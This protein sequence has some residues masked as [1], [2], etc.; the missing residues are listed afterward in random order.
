MSNV[1]TF[2]SQAGTN[3]YGNLWLS[4]ATIAY[5]GQQ[6]G[7]TAEQDILDAFAAMNESSDYQVPSPAPSGEPIA[8]YWQVDWGPVV[9][10]ES[11]GSVANR[12]ANL[13]YVVSYRDNTTHEPIFVAVAIRGTDVHELWT[14]PGLLCVQLA[15]DLD[16]SVLYDWN[17]IISGAATITQYGSASAGP[18]TNAAIAHG[19]WIGLT[20]LRGMTAP[21]NAPLLPNLP[22]TPPA[23]PSPFPNP[24]ASPPPWTVEQYIAAVAAAYPTAPI[25]VT[26]HSLGGCQTTAFGLILAL[27]NP[28]AFVVSHPFA[29]PS[30]GNTKWN[31]IY[32]RTFATT[33]GAPRGQVWW[34]NFDVAPAAFQTQLAQPHPVEPFE[35]SL[36]SNI[37]NMWTGVYGNGPTI[38]EFK[39]IWSKY[40]TL[41]A[42]A[43]THL[44]NSL[45]PWAVQGLQGQQVPA[46]STDW[47]GEL[48]NQ[49]FPKMY[50]TLMSGLKPAIPAFA[51][52]P[53][54][55]D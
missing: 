44:A 12:N 26:G 15:E 11:S 19:T 52:P 6:K 55:Q 14:T 16:I 38:G 25:V 20:C 7:G 39:T 29:P 43:Y 41:A 24:T 10:V 13:M 45:P 8:G 17:D 1:P 32:Q 46:G 37:P 31:A 42:N 22:A 21:L 9:A 5:Y 47:L 3:Y 33:Q 51:P 28:A 35:H 53:A 2:Q 40:N 34:N 36:M 54:A 50:F 4:L 27:E 23:P 48:V 18:S 49:H 30:A